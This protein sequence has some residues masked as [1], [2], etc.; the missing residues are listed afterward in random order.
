MCIYI[1]I[2]SVKPAVFDLILTLAIAAYL[3]IV[4]FFIQVKL[5]RNK[6]AVTYPN[7]LLFKF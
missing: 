4:Y 3:S 7:T 5:H 2:F 1:Y 6:P